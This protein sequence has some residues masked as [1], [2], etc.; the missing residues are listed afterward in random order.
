MAMGVIAV[1]VVMT[2]SIGITAGV[3][4]AVRIGIAVGVFVAMVAVGVLMS[5]GG[6]SVGMSCP[7][8]AGL[9]LRAD[10][11]GLQLPQLHMR[12]KACY[13]LPGPLAYTVCLISR[14]L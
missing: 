7:D 4:V 9:R 13:C 5:V 2:V 12:F 3:F 1:R 14:G 6:G 8:C 10:A 11:S